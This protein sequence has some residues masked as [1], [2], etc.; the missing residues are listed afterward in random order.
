MKGRTG[1]HLSYW[2]L[3]DTAPIW[4]KRV[5][6]SGRLLLEEMITNDRLVQNNGLCINFSSIEVTL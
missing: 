3:F 5:M 4:N 2:M 6:P 1:H